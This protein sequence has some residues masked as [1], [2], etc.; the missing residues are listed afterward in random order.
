[1]TP[2]RQ[3]GRTVTVRDCNIHLP[4]VDI[5]ISPDRLPI[6]HPDDDVP[7]VH[8]EHDSTLIRVIT[9]FPARRC[10]H[11]EMKTGS[12]YEYSAVPM[13]EV[14]YFVGA[15]SKGQFFNRYIRGKYENRRIA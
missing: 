7:M 9:Y 13:Y 4:S 14:F 2:A 5:H 12:L 6:L 11:V 1:M 15:E 8:V 10:L 3:N